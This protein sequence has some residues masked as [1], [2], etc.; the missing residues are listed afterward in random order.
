ME[1]SEVVFDPHRPYQQCPHLAAESG[2]R[3]RLAVASL[4]HYNVVHEDRSI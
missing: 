4:M 1:G 3:A 2:L